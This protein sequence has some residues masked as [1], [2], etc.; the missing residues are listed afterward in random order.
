MFQN[1]FFFVCAFPFYSRLQLAA[2]Q[3][4]ETGEDAAPGEGFGN[5]GR[6]LMQRTISECVR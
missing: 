3:S 2:G 1:F 5:G 4:S 6:V